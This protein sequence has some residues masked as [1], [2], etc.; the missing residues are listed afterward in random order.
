MDDDRMGALTLGG[1][2][3]IVIGVFGLILF[4]FSSGTEPGNPSKAEVVNKGWK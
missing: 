4:Q 1:F 2:L 3:V